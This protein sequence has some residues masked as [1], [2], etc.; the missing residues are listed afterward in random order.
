MGFLHALPEGWSQNR[1]QL[2]T[3]NDVPL[4]LPDIDAG[5]YLAEW[6]SADLGWC[7]ADGMGNLRPVAWSEIDA[8]DR[9]LSLGLEPWEA[10]HIRRMSEA[11][12]EGLHRG[13]TPMVAAPVYA[14]MDEDPGIGLERRLVS[15][16]IKAGL[17]R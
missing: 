16:K 10:R 4:A 9:Q 5:G 11:Y 13:K 15:E 8:L 6:L 2:Y 17:G 7:E 3:K 1:A 12:I 14:S